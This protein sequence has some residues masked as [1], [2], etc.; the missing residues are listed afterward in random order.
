VSER[1][2][3]SSQQAPR[4]IRFALTGLFVLAALILVEKRTGAS[5]P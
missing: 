2:F 3:D 5:P 1:P 4:A